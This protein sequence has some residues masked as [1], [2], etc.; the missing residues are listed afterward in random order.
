ME[1][2]F[3]VHLNKETYANGEVLKGYVILSLSLSPSPSSL[4]PLF[5]MG[6]ISVRVGGYEKA[7]F[8]IPPNTDSYLSLPFYCND[9]VIWSPEPNQKGIIFTFILFYFI[10][11]SLLFVYF[12]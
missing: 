5:K 1:Y 11:F 2:K 6:P 8:Y 9:V 10:Y 4:S 12:C 3:N 7:L